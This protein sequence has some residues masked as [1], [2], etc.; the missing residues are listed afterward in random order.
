L[1]TKY[2]EA[3]GLHWHYRKKYTVTARDRWKSE[4]TGK[5]TTKIKAGYN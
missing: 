1:E 3:E 4:V 5:I 2:R